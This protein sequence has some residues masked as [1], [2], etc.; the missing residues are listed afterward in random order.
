MIIGISNVSE[1]F[2]A[3]PLSKPILTDPPESGRNYVHIT[4]TNHRRLDCLLNRSFRCRSKKT[5]KLCVTG[6]CEGNL[7][8]TWG[9]PSQKAS[10]AEM[11]PFD[12]V[13]MNGKF[14][15]VF[16]D[17]VTFEFIQDPT[18]LL[19]EKKWVNH[20]P[21]CACSLAIPLPLPGRHALNRFALSGAEWG[22]RLP[23]W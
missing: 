21:Q 15:G 22:A 14:A 16:K 1:Q 6:L 9:F 8:V 7:L 2:G 5:S 12:D 11:H 3:K 23:L 19:Q 10:N 4:V 17:E 13:I 20:K 18:T